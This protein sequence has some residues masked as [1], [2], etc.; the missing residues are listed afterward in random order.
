[1]NPSIARIKAKVYDI[2]RTRLPRSP[3]GM[4]PE[5]LDI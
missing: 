3:F 5:E 4:M 2:N 1:M